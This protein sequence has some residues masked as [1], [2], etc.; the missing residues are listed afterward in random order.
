MPASGKVYIDD[1]TFG[2]ASF[3]VLK[4]DTFNDKI[5]FNCIGGGRGSMP[6]SSVSVIYQTAQSS[7]PP[8]AEEID[9][10]VNTTWV[11]TWSKIGGGA[12]GATAQP[13]DLSA[14]HYLTVSVKANSASENPGQVKIEIQT[15]LATSAAYL[16]GITTAWTKYSIRS[17]YSPARLLTRLK[18]NRLTW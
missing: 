6:D 9:Y 7:S 10:N 14:Y 2:T 5:S 4:L 15:P 12:D 3:N 17:A 16:S 8:C 11:G 13:T 1:I 18:L